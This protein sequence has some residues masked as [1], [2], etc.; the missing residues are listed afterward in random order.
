MVNWNGECSSTFS[1]G[2]GVK[3]GGVLSPVLFTV[4]LDGLIDQLRKKGLGCH[5]NG[6]FVGCFMYMQMIL[7]C[8]HHH[9]MH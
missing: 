4:Y 1:F 8:L 7:L 2:D 5:L 6:H 3:Q 9:V